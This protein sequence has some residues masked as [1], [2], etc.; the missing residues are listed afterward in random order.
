MASCCPLASEKE[1]QRPL[2]IE[3]DVVRP[4]MNMPSIDLAFYAP[5]NDIS[6][7]LPLGMKYADALNGSD[8]TVHGGEFTECQSTKNGGFAFASDGSVVTIKGGIVTNNVAARRGGAVRG[9]KDTA[10]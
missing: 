4:T 8:V 1:G 9:C 5:S 3:D 7:S 6:A 2:N 10:T